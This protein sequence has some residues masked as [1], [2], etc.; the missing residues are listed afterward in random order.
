VSTSIQDGIPTTKGDILQSAPPT[1]KKKGSTTKTQTTDAGSSKPTKDTPHR[2]PIW[3]RTAGNKV[4]ANQEEPSAIWKHVPSQSNPADVTLMGIETSIPPTPTTWRKE[5]HK[6]LQ[7]LSMCPATRIDAV[8]DDLNR[9]W[10]ESIAAPLGENTYFVPRITS[11]SLYTADSLATAAIT[12]PTGNEAT[13]TG[14]PTSEVPQTN[15]T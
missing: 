1:A 12:K 8:I 3:R 4:V 6:S 7:E 2:E 14:V 11:R 15:S 13:I 9:K 10:L 5:P